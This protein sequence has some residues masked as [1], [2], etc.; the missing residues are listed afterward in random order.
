MLPNER[1]DALT[2]RS[3]ATDALTQD[4]LELVLQRSRA[5]N[6]ARGITGVLVICGG[7]IVQYIEGPPASLART[8]PVIVASP[9]HRDVTLL[10][11]AERVARRFDCWH[12][13]FARFEPMRPQS[14]EAQEW[15]AILDMLR[16]DPACNAAFA[17]LL[18][19][20]DAIARMPMRTDR[21]A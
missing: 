13:G 14:E 2:Y 15:L 17:A 19:R 7:A 21:A 6:A 1:I 4:A 12:M 5:L 3:E 18:D 8:Y 16:A 20:W 9:L 10:A 11:R